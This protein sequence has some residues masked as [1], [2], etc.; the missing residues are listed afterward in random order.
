MKLTSLILVACMIAVPSSAQNIRYVK[1]VSSGSGDG[2]SWLNASSDIQAMINISA[3]GDEIWVATGT[4]KPNRRS[5]NA[6]TITPGNIHNAFVPKPGLKLYGG[7]SG[8]ETTIAQRNAANLNSSILSGDYNDN[9]VV[10]GEGGFLSM[11]GFTENTNHIMMLVAVS[12][13]TID[14]FVLKGGNEYNTTA[15]VVN[16]LITSTGIGTGLYFNGSNNINITNCKIENN[17]GSGVYLTNG[18]I[19]F[20]NC[21]FIRN[22]ALAG[23]AMFLEN[24]SPSFNHCHFFGNWGSGAGMYNRNAH[25]ILTHC[26]FTY[27]F[28]GNSGGAIY[29][30]EGSAP[31]II[32]CVFAHNQAITQGGAIFNDR[33]GDFTISS[34]TFAGNQV[35]VPGGMQGHAIGGN[36]GSAAGTKTVTLDNCIIWVS[37]S[38]SGNNALAENFGRYV[39]N[40]CL[41]QYTGSGYNVTG[42]WSNLDPQFMN[43]MSPAGLDNLIGTKDDGL[44]VNPASPAVNAGNQSLIPSGLTTDLKQDP[45]ISGTQTDIGAYESNPVSYTVLHV[46]SATGNDNNTGTSWGWPLKTLQKAVQIAQVTHP[47]VDSILVAKGTY[48]PGTWL[49][50]Y[51]TI[52]AGGLK[53]Y[54]GYDIYGNRNIHQKPTVLSAEIGSPGTADNPMHILVIGNIPANADSLVIDGF[55]FA[56][57][58]AGNTGGASSSGVSTLNHSGGA[59]YITNVLNGNK[60]RFRYCSFINNNAITGGG[61]LYNENAQPLFEHC[62]FRNNTAAAG[63]AIVFRNGGAADFVNS[64]F[65]G[66]GNSLIDIAAGCSLSLSSSTLAGNTAAAILNNGNCSVQNSILFKNGGGISGTGS[67]QIQYSLVQG[68]AGGTGN[69]DGNTI[70]D[71]RF[72]NMTD[73][74]YRLQPCSPAINAGNDLLIP[75]NLLSDLDRLPRIQLGTTDLGAFEA[76]SLSGQLATGLSNAQESVTQFQLNNDTTFYA[77]DC[78]TLIAAVAGDSSATSIRGNT[79]VK[80]WVEASQPADFVKR[81][82]EITPADNPLSAT[83]RIILYFTQQDFDNFNSVNAIK[84]PAAPEDATGIANLLIEKRSG[85]SSNGTGHPQSYPGAPVTINPVDTAIKW[86]AGRSRWEISF[87]A[88]SFSGFF[89]K[90]QLQALPLQL[91]FFHVQRNEKEILL[92]WNTGNEM[93]TKQFDI[94]RGN[95]GAKFERIGMVRAKGNG[96][97]AYQFKDNFQRAGLLYYRL[98]ITDQDG[99]Y[100]Y[101]PILILR[102]SAVQ[103]DVIVYPNP[104]HDLLNIQFT[105]R[106]LAGT[107]VQLFNAEGRMVRTDQLRGGSHSINMEAL[108]PGIY[109]LLFQDGSIK[110]IV[111]P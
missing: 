68:H 97:N 80:N 17:Q 61:A 40:N 38:F 20:E 55:T 36:F 83:G 108:K 31:M 48:Y 103:E 104:V 4:Y 73:G 43:Y 109:L 2:S 78:N 19:A 92:Q 32:N 94:E 27:N 50:D 46:D 91:L 89:V 93:N 15:P 79:T 86:N 58:N 54:G 16:G 60:T 1:P 52:T 9:D 71:V 24:T 111:K 33:S 65:T 39:I 74:D 64:V 28:A 12:N 23:A 18:S 62:I 85:I 76:N 13:V 110:R 106:A 59:L 77:S 29:N 35:P 22:K 88:S 37:P 14:G 100:S 102:Q 53:I 70:T 69:L 45:R 63:D 57:G 95:D 30:I 10:T 47:E 107:T 51:L 11:S 101:S 67:S 5:D 90:T 82:V 41:L 26:S 8:N 42:T 7:F 3:S 66:G 87:S 6:N 21:Q 75:S 96:D 99:R 72:A 49:Y 81:H 84:L 34:S 56:N 44:Q 105:K 98:K 25:P